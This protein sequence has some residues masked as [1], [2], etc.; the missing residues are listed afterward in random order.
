MYRRLLEANRGIVQTD[1]Q[2]PTRILIKKMFYF[3]RKMYNQVLF[4]KN[5]IWN[6]K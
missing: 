2:E 1:M 5:K 4:L 6:K 3:P